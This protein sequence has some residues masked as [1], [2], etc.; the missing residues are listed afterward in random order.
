MTIGAGHTLE[1]DN[2]FRPFV[3]SSR[4]DG[5][6]DRWADPF[7]RSLLD[8]GRDITR[9]YDADNYETASEP[10]DRGIR[11]IYTFIEVDIIPMSNIINVHYF[12][13]LH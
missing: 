7:V 1:L 3:M 5:V 2:P 6:T 4:V 9:V 10:E 12:T 11:P 8:L 13:Q